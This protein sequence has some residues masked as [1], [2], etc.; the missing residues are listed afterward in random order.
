MVKGGKFWYFYFKIFMR[1]N[2]DGVVILFYYIEY[3]KV[4]NYK[5]EN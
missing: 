3:I 1:N 5:R 4:E 2:G